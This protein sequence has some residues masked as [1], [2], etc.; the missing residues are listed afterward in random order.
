MANHMDL[1]LEFP[2]VEDTGE[3]FIIGLPVVFIDRVYIVDISRVYKRGRPEYRLRLVLVN[4]DII[5]M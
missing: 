1:S 2:L 5:W 3:S 4:W